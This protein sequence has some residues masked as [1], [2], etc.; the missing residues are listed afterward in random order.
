MK[1][2]KCNNNAII[3]QKYSGVHLCKEHFIYDVE[4]KIKRDMRKH[5][6]I[7]QN[8]KVAVA[9]SGGKDSITLLYI[10]HKVFCKR[11]DIDLIAITINEGISGYREKTLKIAKDFTKQLEIEHVI[12]SFKDTYDFDLDEIVKN[13]KNKKLAPCTFCGVLRKTLLNKTAKELGATKLAT[14]HNLDDESQTVLLNHLRG[15]VE[16]LVRLAPEKPQPG[17]ILRIKPLRNI[18]EKEVAL[19]AL[20]NNL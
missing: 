20:V 13:N 5:S 9:L 10:L 17:L 15:D 12:V 1:C 16:R 8:D 19:Y 4:R 18:P 11:E 6:M 3:Y 2:T 7:L 14:G